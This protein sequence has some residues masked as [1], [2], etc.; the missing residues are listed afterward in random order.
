M[1]I[2]KYLLIYHLRDTLSSLTEIFDILIVK[3]FEMKSPNKT[4]RSMNQ[5]IQ[6]W[7]GLTGKQNF[8]ALLT[9]TLLFELDVLNWTKHPG[10][11]QPL[12][13]VCADAMLLKGKRYKQRILKTGAITESSKI[14]STI[15]WKP[16]RHPII[17][18]VLFNPKEMLEGLGKLLTAWCLVV[19]ATR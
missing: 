1:F 5:K 15:K 14:E 16:L 18:I 3:I 19:R 6:S 13:K 12:R 2:G 7:Y 11:I 4:G 8:C 9:H 17:T 10:L